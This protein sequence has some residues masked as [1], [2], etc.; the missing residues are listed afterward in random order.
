MPVPYKVKYND[1]GSKC[2]RSIIELRRK[3]ECGILFREDQ[4]FKPH[5]K[6][7][8]LPSDKFPVKRLTPGDVPA[9]KII[10]PGSMPSATGVPDREDPRRLAYTEVTLPQDANTLTKVDRRGVPPRTGYNIIPREIPGFL[11]EIPENRVTNVPESVT[12]RSENFANQEMFIINPATEENEILKAAEKYLRRGRDFIS[13]SDLDKIIKDMEPR[14]ITEQ[15]VRDVI[16]EYNMMDVA[17]ENA[18]GAISDN[19]ARATMRRMKA[20]NTLI[21]EDAT[22]LRPERASSFG[23]NEDTNLIPRTERI[24]NYG[25][26]FAPVETEATSKLSEG[27]SSRATTVSQDIS[28]YARRAR[29]IMSR[30]DYTSVDDFDI[31]DETVFENTPASVERNT[32]L[33]SLAENQRIAKTRFAKA[34][35]GFVRGRSA[36]Y[37]SVSGVDFELTDFNNIRLPE[38]ST[39]G[40]GSTFGRSSLREITSTA[41]P[42]ERNIAGQ[43]RVKI[44]FAD[45]ISAPRISDVATGTIHTVGGLGI[46]Y[47]IS[48]LLDK[49]KVNKYVNAFTSVALGD[50]G[51]RIM[52]FGAQRAMVNAGLRTAEVE[53]ITSGSLIR[54]GLEGGALGLAAMP[55]QNMLVRS[56]RSTG[57]SHT[58]SNM[59]GAGVVSTG[60][61]AAIYGAGAANVAD[62][63]GLSLLA[64][65]IANGAIELMAYVQGQSEDQQVEKLITSNKVR[66]DFVNTLPKYNYNYAKAL[67]AFNN[68]DGLDMDSPSYKSFED[69]LDEAFV[70]HP[71]GSLVRPPDNKDPSADQIKMSNLYGKY[72]LHN[73][74]Q[75]VCKGSDECSPD[76]ISRDQGK[77]T[78]NEINFLNDQTDRTWQSQADVQVNVSM[79]QMNYTQSRVQ[80]AKE[81]VIANWE[82]RKRLPDQM[83]ERTVA[84]ANLDPNFMPAFNTAVKL[85][86]QRTVVNAF[87]TNQTKMEQ[88]P[89][90]I[91]KMAQLDKDFYYTI[92]VFYRDTE[93]EAS[94][95]NLNVPQLISLQGLSTEEQNTKYRG[96]QFDYA[97]MNEKTIKDARS[98][99]KEEDTV[100]EANY[101]DIDQAYL[102]TDPTA[103]GNWK[104]SDSQILQA[105]SAGFSLQQYVDYLHELAKGPDGDFSNLPV[106]SKEDTRASGILDFSHF[107]DELQMGG[108]DKDMYSYN[109]DT[110]SITINKGYSAIPGTSNKFVSKY[111]PEN[112]LRNRQHTVD[113]LHGLDRQNQALVDEYNTD[114]RKHLSV[115]GEN[116]NKQVASINDNRSYHGQSN[117]LVFDEQA[118]Y[119]RNHIEFKPATVAP[120]IRRVPRTARDPEQQAGNYTGAPVKEIDVKTQAAEPM[121]TGKNLF[122]LDDSGN[123][124][125]N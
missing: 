115:F 51:G 27:V 26:N 77:L 122:S 123:I 104:P 82:D 20:M 25:T 108:F 34:S 76:L 37:K 31:V 69:G 52:S 90:N 50:V 6:S 1:S 93:N 125:D 18:V 74:I 4:P 41:G 16:E 71:K 40:D 112:V 65:A 15:R 44:S 55:L 11:E 124:V 61:T 85:E 12:E 5:R 43:R 58:A 103:V 118:A 42:L 39:I 46:A 30:N 83:D 109:P 101:Y 102:T 38:T 64:A 19:S 80:R 114:L 91:Q 67:D 92:H 107:E 2:P 60:L 78:E 9:K 97:K 48:S 113:L 33:K 8:D 36:G 100:R 24:P 54:G 22:I 94:K 23:I 13:S 59:I 35:E 98:I 121:E 95:M 66:N 87:Y 106:Y 21:R 81:E 10:P 57:Q 29:G 49:A 32:F 14:S 89:E 3:P 56:L 28:Y 63:A 96:Y 7:F 75:E 72:I 68:K 111:T 117:L 120:P 70:T 45:R 116:Y 119:E 88:L 86:A 62:T 84:E 110:L 47:G 79:K 99:S 17:F 105:H 53:T 73:V